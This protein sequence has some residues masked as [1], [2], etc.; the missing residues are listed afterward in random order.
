MMTDQEIADRLYGGSKTTP[1][2]DA[3]APLA[4]LQAADAPSEKSI[5][6]R[7]Y[8]TTAQED[9]TSNE[10]SNAPAEDAKTEK[11]EGEFKVELPEA[12]AKLRQEDTT[13]RMY[14]AES[15]YKSSDGLE[16]ALGDAVEIPAEVQTAAAAEYREMFADMQLE[17]NEARDVVG[18]FRHVAKNP[19]DEATERE[20]RQASLTQLENQHGKQEVGKALELARKLV[21]RDPRVDFLLRYT[22]LGSHP[23]VVAL[24]V[25]KARS[26]SAAGRL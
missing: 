21:Q 2:A 5:E 19:A 11:P 6:E 13:R 25:Q 24:L 7:M 16:D 9:Q 1:A 10:G 17:P 22:G 26:E 12:I 15:V 8:N 3:T 23:K 18:L 14:S 4:E 20:W